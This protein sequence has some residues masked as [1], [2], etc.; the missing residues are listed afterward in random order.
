I[1]DDSLLDKSGKHIEG[2]G[3]VHNHVTNLHVLGYK[4]LVCGFWDGRSFIPLDFSL[5][6]EK[7]G[8][9]LENATKRV[10]VMG[11]RIEKKENEIKAL[12]AKKKI[13]KKEL[14]QTKVGSQK[15]KQ[16]QRVIAKIDD[17]LAKKR[18]E[19][20]ELKKRME[21]LECKFHDAKANYK[22]C[23]LASK[24]HRNQFKKKREIGSPG[25]KRKKELDD[26]K[27]DIAIRMLCRS[28]GMGF[29]PD[30]VVTDT[31]FFCHK[32]LKAVIETGRTVNL[33][34]MAQMGKAKYELLPT[35]K[36]LNPKEIVVRYER[37][38][39]KWNR[40]YKSRYIKVK[41]NYMGIRVNLFLVKMGRQKNWRMLVT[42]DLS[43]SF[44]KLI[45]I[46]KIRWTIEVFFKECK[47]N[48]YLGKCQ[49]TD[50]DAQIADTSLSLIRYI[51]LSHYE[52]LHYGVTIGGL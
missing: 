49:S 2:I 15:Q 29:V 21:T 1:F 33:V 35:G 22:C 17:S 12:K 47:Q 34:S 44:P 30:Y 27:I 38:E 6:R 32:L 51:M 39:G 9:D 31:W 41:A 4:L 40:Q 43:L 24:E 28:V 37:T 52:R 5:H 48:L 46:Y 7:R 11:S 13:K 25:L 18:E 14:S 45:E 20:R 19:L 23:G 10:N 50:F 16:K 42:T 8:K 36:F 26:N 3:M